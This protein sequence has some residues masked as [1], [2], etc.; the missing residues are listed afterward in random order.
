MAENPSNNGS[1]NPNDPLEEFLK[2]LQEQGFDP[3][4]QTGGANAFG[5]SENPF[6]GIFSLPLDGSLNPEDLKNMGLP[7]DPG[8]LQGMMSQMQSLFNGQGGSVERGVNWNQVKDQ[9]QQI[10]RRGEDPSVPNNLE[11]AT[12]DAANLADLWLDTATT[13]ER[14]NI[15]LEAWGKSEWLDILCSG[16][17]SRSI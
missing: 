10:I 13:F 14:H 12:I 17:S 6:N 8:M 2:K 1:N 7:F 3:T 15:P 4:A 9:T 5:A 16:S 11:Q